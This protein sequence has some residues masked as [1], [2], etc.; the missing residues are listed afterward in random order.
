MTETGMS[1]F[2]IFRM[3]LVQTALGAI[4]VLTTSTINRVMVVELALPALLPGLLVALHYALQSLRPRWGHGSDVGGRRTPWIVFG[5]AILAAGGVGAA[6]AT[7]LMADHYYFGL[8]VA[9]LS[10]T[11][12]GIGVGATGTNLLAMVATQ[13]SAERRAAAATIIWMMMI[14]GFIV[15]TVAAGTY[16]DPFSTSRLVSVAAVVSATAFLVSVAALY[17]L[18]ERA[19]HRALKVTP[20]TTEVTFGDSLKQVWAERRS[21]QFAIFVFVSMIAYSMQDLILEPFAGIVFHLTPGQTTKLSG[22]QNAG[23]FCGMLLVAVVANPRI[24]IG[25][26]KLWTIAGCIGSML[27]LCALIFSGWVGDVVAMKSAVFALGFANGAYAIA[28]ISSMMAV[29]ASGRQRREGMRMGV[30]GASQALAFGSGGF[31]GTIAV[32]GLR[33]VMAEPSSAYLIVFGFEAVLFALSAAMALRSD[34]ADRFARD[35]RER[36]TSDESYAMAAMLKR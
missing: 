10:F 31:F 8:A 30:F 24:A 11:C 26:L 36:A 27:A 28:A 19:S 14:A 33:H 35:R 9:V 6:I 25:S 3:G 4:V 22:L 16:L 13:V 18:E 23:V 21:R 2:S 7:A 29:A 20:T 1:W 15:T 34:E 17:K 5:M 32:D 12:V